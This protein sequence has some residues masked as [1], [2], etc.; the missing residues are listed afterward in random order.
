M[1]AENAK[2]VSTTEQIISVFVP[3]FKKN[4]IKNAYLF[5]SFA[6]GTEREES[7]IDLLV[8]SD[9]EGFAFLSFVQELEDAAGRSVDCFDVRHIVNGSRFEN[10]IR[11]SGVLLYAN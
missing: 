11:E 2:K 9:L 6:K 7:D 4:N 1:Q 10:E 8:E 3:L 5:G